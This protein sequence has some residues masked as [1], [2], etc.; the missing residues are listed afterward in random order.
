M[1][2]CIRVRNTPMYAHSLHRLYAQGAFTLRVDAVETFLKKNS[3]TAVVRAHEAQLEGYGQDLVLC[4]FT[5]D[6][7]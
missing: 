6:L 4:C 3:L 1:L 5:I 7:G 2:F